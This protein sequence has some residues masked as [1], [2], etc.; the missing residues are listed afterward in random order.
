[1]AD[2][3]ETYADGTVIE[4][5]FTDEEL[6]QIAADKEEAKQIAARIKALENVKKAAEL[7]LAN[8]GF[9]KDELIALGLA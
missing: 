9:T 7:K 1:M 3:I 8:L 2:V 4:R 6:A 5:D